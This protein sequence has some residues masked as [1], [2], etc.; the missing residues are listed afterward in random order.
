MTDPAPRPRRTGPLITVGVAF[1]LL[2][3][4]AYAA[5]RTC[6]GPDRVLHAQEPASR[7][8]AIRF[9]NSG[10][11]AAQ[12]DFTRGVLLLHSFEYG[13]AVEAFRA[14]QAR[15]PG[16]ALAYWGEALALTHP[17]WNEQDS[18]AARAVLARLG[19]TPEARSARA[20]TH[21]ERMY[22]DA[23]EV[24][25]GP[26]PKAARDSAYARAMDR[27]VA[28][29]PDDDEARTF[30]A[31][32]WM[33]QSQGIR[34]VPTY[35]RAGAE[36]LAV[37][38]RQP[39]HPGAAHYAIHAFD[40]PTHAPLALS[41]ARAYSA[42]APGAAHAQHMTTHI[43]LALGMWEDVV[44]QNVI[45]SGPDTSRWRPGHYTAW[46]GYG[47]LQQGR[48]DDARRHLGQVRDHLGPGSPDVARGYLT[49]MIAEYVVNS[50]R[51]DAPELQWP[52]APPAA[53]Q[54]A[55]ASYAYAEGVAALRR[56]DRASAESALG[57]IRALGETV[58]PGADANLSRNQVG[59]IGDELEALLRIG[60]GRA[61]EG[62][63]LLRA[64]AVRDDELPVEYGP[65]SVVK[66]AWELLGEEL[67]R[68]G[69]GA[70]A[71]AAFARA[72]EVHPG[73]LA[74]IRG[75]LASA[76]ATGDQEEMA[77][78]RSLLPPS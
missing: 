31:L 70:E 62:L 52:V 54:P 18:V 39:E 13:S 47:L 46:L 51:W 9:P 74:A 21:R 59:I 24:L 8:G 2:T 15:D 28:A 10:A 77:R 73:R 6:A 40:D 11:A 45:A 32:A 26:G 68:G 66:P 16:F 17:L 63:D 72:L 34:D 53:W 25:Y 42:I 60:A 5:W 55:R 37:R 35:V 4:L 78:A 27:L 41:A 57:R 64:A 22:L 36:A 44:A 14:A 43:F 69:R 58:R 49:A 38:A 67:L 76:E 29:H 48:Y 7:L 30:R 1:C 19:A 75:L 65:P 3:A 56:G 23:V 50:G 12:G 33:G 71:R 20:P 61:E